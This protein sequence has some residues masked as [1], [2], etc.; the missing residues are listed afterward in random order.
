[1][2]FDTP[3]NFFKHAFI[4]EEK[5]YNHFENVFFL[6]SRRRAYTQG[7]VN[8]DFHSNCCGL[9]GEQKVEKRGEKSTLTLLFLAQEKKWATDEIMSAGTN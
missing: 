6:P 2:A 5:E 1:M 8:N 4:A 9:H 7:L 3:V